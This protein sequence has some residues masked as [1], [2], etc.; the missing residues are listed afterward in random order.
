VLEWLLQHMSELKERA[1]L[2][3]FLVKVDI[4]Q[5]FMIDSQIAELYEQVS[6]WLVFTVTCWTLVVWV[7]SEFLII[8]DKRLI[9]KLLWCH[10]TMR[11]SWNVVYILAYKVAPF[12]GIDIIGAVMIVWKGRGK[13]ENYQ[14]CSVQL[15]QL[16]TVQCTCIWTDLTVVCWLDVAFLWLYSVLQFVYVR[17]S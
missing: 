7:D 11:S 5:D 16:C 12:P 13:R 14:F 8:D 9:E 10:I 1:Y 17:F 2:A 15:Q 3:R 6:T 4:P